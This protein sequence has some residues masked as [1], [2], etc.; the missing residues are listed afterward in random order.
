[1]SLIRQRR[2]RKT[3]WMDTRKGMSQRKLIAYL[4]LVVVAIW[5]LS[6][7]F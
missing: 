4:F 1:M 3:N 2:R 7:A 6:W 5:Y